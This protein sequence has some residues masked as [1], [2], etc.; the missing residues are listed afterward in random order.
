M[1]EREQLISRNVTITKARGILEALW[2]M[3]KSE[4]W[5]ENRAQ[6]I[7]MDAGELWEKELRDNLF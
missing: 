4:D 6:E 3:S 1:T 5:D 7:V 2:R